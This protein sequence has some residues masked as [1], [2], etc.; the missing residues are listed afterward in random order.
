MLIGSQR[1]S[2]IALLSRH[3]A[4][5][6]SA[7][8]LVAARLCNKLAYRHCH[9]RHCSQTLAPP[10]SRVA[11]DTRDLSFPAFP[12][13]LRRIFQRLNLLRR[14][15]NEGPAAATATLHNCKRVKVY[16]KG[17]TTHTYSEISHLTLYSA[18]SHNHHM[19]TH[20][21]SKSYCLPHFGLLQTK[22]YRRVLHVQHRL[23]GYPCYRYVSH[24]YSFR[25]HSHSFGCL[26][27]VIA[28]NGKINFRKIIKAAIIY[29]ISYVLKSVWIY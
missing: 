16:C 8:L 21:P 3:F 29:I 11:A 10:P 18:D 27:A 9:R 6:R 24:S 2:C 17:I 22:S 7:W 28:R 12:I 20:S 23:P 1:H 5:F 26:I 15:I 14:A 19:C 25:I 4:T 13:L